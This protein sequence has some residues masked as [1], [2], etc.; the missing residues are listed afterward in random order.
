VPSARAAHI[1]A[2]IVQKYVAERATRFV[3]IGDR[4]HVHP[5]ILGLPAASGFGRSEEPAGTAKAGAD[6]GHLFWG[7]DGNNGGGWIDRGDALGRVN[8]DLDRRARGGARRLDARGTLDN[9]RE[10]ER[11]ERTPRVQLLAVNRELMRCRAQGQSITN[12]AALWIILGIGPATHDPLHFGG[13]STDCCR[14]ISNG[15]GFAANE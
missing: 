10:E 2:A 6:R 3:S 15:D 8:G 13:G 1:G 11:V 4:H 14:E 9:G 5:R 12:N 7:N